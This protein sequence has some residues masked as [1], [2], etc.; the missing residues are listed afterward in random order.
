MTFAALPPTALVKAA[1]E[2]TVSGVAL[3]PPVVVG[4]FMPDCEAQPINALPVGGEVQ[5]PVLVLPA[6]L[7]APAAPP[8]VVPPAPPRPALPLV[9]AEPLEPALP[10]RDVVAP[11]EPV[12][13]EPSA[14]AA[15]PESLAALPAPPES[16]EPH[17]GKRFSA[18]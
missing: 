6:A 3:P 17:P 11:P 10:P 4:T 16:A 1:S 8:L 14:P 15:A 12:P 18:H 13:L 7:T 9:P 2:V 5:L